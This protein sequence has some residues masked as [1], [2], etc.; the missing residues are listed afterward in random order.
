M[1]SL[2][3]IPVETALAWRNAM[4]E[5]LARVG[6]EKLA[7][8]NVI[9]MTKQT[10]VKCRVGCILSCVHVWRNFFPMLHNNFDVKYVLQHCESLKYLMLKMRQI[11][12]AY[13]LSLTAYTGIARIP[14]G[15]HY[16]LCNK[17][18]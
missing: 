17:L 18:Q 4:I 9:G 11:S 3:K 15:R 12:T 13:N 16:V 5:G 8:I 7:L 10:S 1:L 14:S 6:D 2:E